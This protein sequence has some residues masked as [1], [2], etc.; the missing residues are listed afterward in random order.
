MMNL[1]NYTATDAKFWKGRVDD[2]DDIDSYRMHQIIKL[3]DLNDFRTLKIDSSKLNICLLAYC[4]DEGIKRNLG[5]TGAKH[6]PEDIRNEFANLPVSFG[7]KTVIYDA[8][9]LFCYEGNMEEAQEQLGIAIETILAN[10]MFPIVLGG[11][12]ELAY[13]HFNGIVNHLKKQNR[14]GSKIGIINFDAHFD[15]RPY[16]NQGSS[17][18]MF[19]QIADKCLQENLAFDYMCLGIQTSANTRSLFNKADS[20]G[21]KYVLAKEF[22]DSN[23]GSIS[24][25]IKDFINGHD[26]IYLSLCSDVFNSAFAPGVSSIQPF[27]LYPELVLK[28]IKQILKSKKVISF[29]IAEVSPRFDYDK[30]TAKLAAIIIYAV[31]NSLSEIR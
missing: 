17:G 22:I 23:Q 8:G 10:Q 21:V 25:K 14:E 13:G 31:I 27:G 15:L 11:S 29:D 1:K 24:T 9:S 19:S 12:H 20:L 2:L 28:F 16:N 18:T 26:H 6:G 30:R 3:I 4:C 7:D 5:R